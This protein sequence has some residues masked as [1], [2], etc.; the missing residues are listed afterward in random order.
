MLKIDTSLT[1]KSLLPAVEK[2]FTLS[3]AKI[4]DIERTW[5]PSEAGKTEANQ[6]P[7]VAGFHGAGQVHVARLDGVDAGVSVRLGDSSV[8]RD[9]RTR[10]SGLGARQTR[11]K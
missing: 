1:A 3:A 6:A 5:N 4:R 10:V 9:E 11:S 8:R 7:A 2:L